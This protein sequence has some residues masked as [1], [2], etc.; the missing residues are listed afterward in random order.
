MVLN[1][2]YELRNIVG[3]G[4]MAVTYEAI[5]NKTNE[6]II[7]KVTNV[8]DTLSKTKAIRECEMLMNLRHEN[9]V[10]VY[11]KVVEGNKVYMIME[12]I[13]GETLREYVRRKDINEEEALDIMLQLLSI[14]GYLH[15]QE[16]IIIYRDL[17]PDNVMINDRTG[18]IKLIDFGIARTYK[19]QKHQ[20]TECLGTPGFAPREQYGFEQTDNRSDI[21]SLGATIYYLM[22]KNEPLTYPRVNKPLNAIMP[23]IDVQFSD[24]IEKAMKDKKED[25]YQDCN[26][27]EVEA[28]NC[29]KRLRGIEEKSIEIEQ[30]FEET[31]ED[32]FEKNIGST[33]EEKLRRN[34]E[35]NLEDTFE[36]IQ[37]IDED[38][39][40]DESNTDSFQSREK[41]LKGLIIFFVF[42]IIIG[43]IK[44]L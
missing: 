25:R 8:E 29:L 27:F 30:T 32:T 28:I 33:F 17:T 10:K 43:L 42:I 21:Y 7:I 3:K 13:H 4:G 2:R 40:E 18:H 6:N 31:L 36:E 11:D 41:L 12:K 16:P 35:D 14:F 19:E 44:L 22:T 39:E 9:I 38:F 15:C 5:D 34:F 37:S 20:D 26:E 1:D 24:M 23:E